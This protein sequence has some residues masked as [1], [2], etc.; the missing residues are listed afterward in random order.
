VLWKKNLDLLD[1]LY[2]EFMK[3]VKKLPGK[4][5]LNM[6]IS[7]LTKIAAKH[8]DFMMRFIYG[9]VCSAERGVEDNDP[10]VQSVSRHLLLE[11]AELL[12]RLPK[13]QGD[14]LT[15]LLTKHIHID[16]DKVNITTLND[17]LEILVKHELGKKKEV[18]KSIK[19]MKSYCKKFGDELSVLRQG[20][21]E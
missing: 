2:K 15:Q 16:L 11:C 13:D 1:P 21:K 5:T 6:G 14:D 7:K 10:R 19:V 9:I 8:M 3:G 17:A 4:Q 18:K 20:K 12:M